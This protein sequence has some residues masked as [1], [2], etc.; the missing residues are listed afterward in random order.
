MMKAVRNTAMY[1]RYLGHNCNCEHR[2]TSFEHQHPNIDFIAFLHIST[3]D[4][5]KWVIFVIWEYN[6]N[7]QK[8]GALLF[9]TLGAATHPPC[10]IL[11]VQQSLT[12]VARFFGRPVQDLSYF[13]VKPLFCDACSLWCSIVLLKYATP[14]WKRH[15]DSPR[16]RH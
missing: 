8:V 6:H 2:R 1:F 3:G 12:F 4:V 5:N 7:S 13:S 9:L 15:L 11:A 16:H 10:R 14:H